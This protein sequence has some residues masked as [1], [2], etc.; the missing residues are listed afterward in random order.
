MAFPSALMAAMV[1]A[2]GTAVTVIN[3]AISGIARNAI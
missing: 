2:V 1:A 3:G